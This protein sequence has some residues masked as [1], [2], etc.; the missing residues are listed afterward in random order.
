M[1][2]L[3]TMVNV[4]PDNVASSSSIKCDFDFFSTLEENPQINES[5]EVSLNNL[6]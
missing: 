6:G 2:P 1:D 5:Q 4:D 3:F